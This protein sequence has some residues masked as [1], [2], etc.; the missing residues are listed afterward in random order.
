MMLH[1]H[2]RLRRTALFVFLL[3][4]AV[5]MYALSSAG[6][7]WATPSQDALRSTLPPVKEGE[8]STLVEP[9]KTTTLP[10]AGVSAT[11]TIKPGSVKV[12]GKVAEVQIVTAP[13]PAAAVPPKPPAPTITFLGRAVEINVYDGLGADITGKVFFNPPLEIVFDISEAEWTAVGGDL[14]QFNVRYYNPATAEW[15]SLA[16]TVDPV[17][18]RKA[19]AYVSHLT[20]FGLFRQQP[21]PAPLTPT[22]TKPP[23]PGG[24]ASVGTEG[25]VL[26]GLLGLLLVGSGAYYLRVGRRQSS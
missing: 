1:G 14:S 6:V 25:L 9:D 16:T 20:V 12:D 4:G 24:D 2:N 8:T 10:V 18:P 11:I 3:V 23:I 17:P 19:K 21:T 15:V 22:A 26:L 13:K 7:V 5:L